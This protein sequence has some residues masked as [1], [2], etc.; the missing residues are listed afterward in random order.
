MDRDGLR[1]R[2]YMMVVSSENV[3]SSRTVKNAPKG[4]ENIGSLG[5]GG[6]HAIG[7]DND[8]TIPNVGFG[9]SGLGE[10]LLKETI[11]EGND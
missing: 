11:R 10:K 1:P 5:G 6:V 4:L 2:I 9:V 3:D 8:R 7:K